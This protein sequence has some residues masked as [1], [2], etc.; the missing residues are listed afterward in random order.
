MGERANVGPNVEAL[1]SHIWKTH[2]V[3]A[4]FSDA[5]NETSRRARVVFGDI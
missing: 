5:L 4:V 3:G 2:E 1:A